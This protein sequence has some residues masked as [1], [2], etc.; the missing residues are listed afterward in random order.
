VKLH[1]I[2]DTHIG[3]IRSGGTNP[4][5]AFA[6]RTYILERFNA[7]LDACTEG[8]LLINGDLF[9]TFSIPYIDLLAAFDALTSWLSDNKG[10]V[11]HLAAGN[12]DLS[13]T[14]STMSSF[15]FLGRL[16]GKHPRV[17]IYEEPG[18]I[19][20][21]DDMWVIP[22]MP[23]QDLFDL[24][25]T[26]VPKGM[27]YVFM[28]CNFDNK[29]AQ[30]QDHSLNLS[31]EQARA[32]DVERIV[33]GHEH[34]RSMHLTGKVMVPGNQIPSSVADCLGNREKFMVR[35]EDTKF[36]SIVVWEAK[37]SFYRADWHELSKVPDDAQFIRVEGDAAASEAAAVVSLIAKLRQS[38][39][40]FVITNAVQ[41]EGRKSD[42]EKATLEKVQS[43][44]VWQALLA[45]IKKPE[46]KA[47]LTKLKEENNVQH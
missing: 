32:L 46:W 4:A 34:Q 43:F 24:A 39:K 15:Q 28:H 37:G 35:I 17:M 12:H 31:A 21:H 25:L 27:K 3:A 36:E 44:D 14:T 23:N 40:A 18:L 41:I 20:G 6:L 47:K 42:T 13:K 30:Q 45:K 8:D 9:D 38:H 2:N 1:V 5:S 33:L 19:A 26:R 16:L 10:H 7:L 22:H 29:F 11:L